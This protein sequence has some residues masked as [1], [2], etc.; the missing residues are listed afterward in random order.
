[1]KQIKKLVTLLTALVLCLVPLFGNTMTVNA[2]GT[3]AT[4]YVKYVEG[5]NQWRFQPDTWV[6]NGY[7]RELY[8]MQQ[9]IKDGDVL[10]ID[11][12]RTTNTLSLEL[13]VSLSNLTISESGIVNITATSVDNCYIIQN[14]QGIVN[15]P[16][17]NAYVY[18]KSL[19]QF[20]A[21]VENLE[22]IS[23]QGELLH[24]TVGTNGT[25]KHLKAY[26]SYVHYEFYDFAKGALNIVDGTLKSTAG[27]YSK[28]PSATTT[29]AAP[30]T[31]TPAAPSGEYDDVPKTADIRFNPLWLV[32]LAGAC[33]AGS[34]A[35]KKEK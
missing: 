14:A 22:V 18:D 8:Y 5:I 25:V 15:A 7:H 26:S 11:G 34:Y 17:K 9:D 16:V 10:I 33:F 29:P 30:T 20:N 2:A 23:S 21:D 35:L 28:T 32:V 3:P 31:S 6:E 13:Y 19:G 27:T 4:Y 12:A 1:M 24:G